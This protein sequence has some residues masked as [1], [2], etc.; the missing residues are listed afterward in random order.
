MF[1]SGLVR[2]VTH[3]WNGET[4]H[5]EFMSSSNIPIEIEWEKFNTYEEGK[6]KSKHNWFWVISDPSRNFR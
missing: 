1:R 6:D 5:H 3:D 2:W 4:K